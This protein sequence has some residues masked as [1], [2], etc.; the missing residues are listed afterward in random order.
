MSRQGAKPF[1]PRCHRASAPA[2]LTAAYL[3]A[4]DG[5][6]GGSTQRFST[7]RG[8]T[9]AAASPQAVGGLVAVYALVPSGGG[10]HA[11]A[12]GAAAAALVYDIVDVPE[13]EAGGRE[14]PGAGHIAGELL[15]M[16]PSSAPALP[17]RAV[18][19]DSPEG[20]RF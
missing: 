1:K 3:D 17:A 2:E 8:T 6:W 4:D 18:A 10:A 15:V 11:A 12:A 14:L 13:P 7:A 16:P 9:L 19:R 5:R 20:G